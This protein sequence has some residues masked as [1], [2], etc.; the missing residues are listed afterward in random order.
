MT[1][2]RA[3]AGG[4]RAPGLG[5]RVAAGALLLGE[6][7]V[8][9]VVAGGTTALVLAWAGLTWRTALVTGGVAAVA[10]TLAAWVASTVPPVPGPPPGAPGT[11]DGSPDESG[12]GSARPAP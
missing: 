12:A 3:A 6:R 9:G 7:L 2:G 4:D 10:V 5:A 11:D 1:S 8:L